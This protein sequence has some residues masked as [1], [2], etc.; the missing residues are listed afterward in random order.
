[1]SGRC[2]ISPD[3]FS[4]SNTCG[5]TFLAFGGAP[6]P[7]SVPPTVPPTTPPLTPPAT[8][9]ST[10]PSSPS[11][12]SFFS[13]SSFGCTSCGTVE[14]V[15]IFFSMCLTSTC[16]RAG[17]GGGGGGGGALKNVSDSAGGV[18]SST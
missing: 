15:T 14:G 8:P 2:G 6:V 9:P 3:N 12:S 17:G 4:E 11:S 7:P 16:L 5:G 10:P 18:I 1:M 13:S